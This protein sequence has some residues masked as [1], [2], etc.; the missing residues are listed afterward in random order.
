[1]PFD[2]QLCLDEREDAR[3][4]ATVILV[5]DCPLTLDGVA[6]QLF[7]AD[8]ESLSSK[9]LLPVSGDLVGPVSSRVQLRS[10]SGEIPVGSQVIATAWWDGGQMQAS[11]CTDPGTTLQAHA[12][13]EMV[14]AQTDEEVLLDVLPEERERMMALFPWMVRPPSTKALEHEQSAEDLSEDMGLDGDDA[15]WLKDLMNEEL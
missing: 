12:L 10:S 3:V 1:M 6:V 8:G 15:E 14:I 4:F 5:P 2:F 9:L 13:A 7:D 11:R